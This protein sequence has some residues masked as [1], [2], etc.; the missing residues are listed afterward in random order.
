VGSHVIVC[1]RSD[2]PM[3]QDVPA[4][5]ATTTKVTTTRTTTTYSPACSGRMPPFDLPEKSVTELDDWHNPSEEPSEMAT[6]SPPVVVSVADDRTAKLSSKTTGEQVTVQ[7][8]SDFEGWDVLEITP[9][10][11]VV[12]LEQA[13]QRWASIAFVVQGRD[14]PLATVRKPVGQIDALEQP[15]YHLEEVDSDWYCK[16]NHDV[17]D[18][19]GKVAGSISDGEP[20][21][22][23]ASSVFAPNNDNGIFGNP[24]E[25]AKWVLRSDGAVKTQDFPRAGKSGG[26]VHTSFRDFLPTS[27]PQHGGHAVWESSKGGMVGKHLRVVEQGFWDSPSACGGSIMAVSPAAT[28]QD[29]ESTAL[30]RV[31]TRASTNKSTFYRRLRVNQTSSELLGIDELDNGDDFFDAVLAQYHRWG[32]FVGFGSAPLLPDSDRRYRD[33]PNA[34]LTAYLNNFRGMTP[35]YGMG[36]FAN[37][38][39]EFLPLDTLSLHEGLLEWGHHDVSRKYLSHFF[40]T[41][42]NHT[43]GKIIYDIFNCDGDAD[44]GRLVSTYVKAA[45]YSGDRKWAASLLPVIENMAN[46]I[47]QARAATMEEFPAESLLHGLARGSP[48]HDLCGGKSFFFNVNVWMIRGLL[49]LDGFLKESGLSNDPSIEVRLLPEASDW[50]VRLTAAANY[51]AVRKVD[52]SVFFLHPCVGSDCAKTPVLKQGGLEKNCVDAGICF[53]SMT[54]DRK[55]QIA[56]YA[57]FRFYSET[58]FATVLDEEYENGIITFRDTHRGTLTGMTRFRDVL[59]DMPILGYG[60]GLLSHDKVEQF[61]T[62]LAG[63]SANY[64]SRGT[65]WGTEQRQQQQNGGIL[66]D[67]WTNNCGDGGEDCSLCMVSSMPPAMWVRWML[68][69]ESRDARQVHLAR[70]APKR[71][72]TQSQAFGISAAPTRFG[73][74]SYSL[75]AVD[76]SI[77]GIVTLSAHPGTED[78]EN[79]LYS[80]RLISP[81]WKDGLQLDTVDVSGAMVIAIHQNNNT[82]VFSPDA[83]AGSFNFTATFAKGG[84]M[85]V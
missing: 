8:G 48:E 1:V 29:P 71:W 74:V 61:H 62:L 21:F 46:H 85:L 44:Y 57:N 25:L 7:V 17:E 18:W 66:D 53:P 23:A 12:V 9:S 54:A 63:H 24:E 69:Q 3:T 82:V 81:E 67:R 45:R 35:E 41:F 76:S 6:L 51:T 11:K 13:F 2:V 43:D 42:I 22:N 78:A 49:D 55:N 33:M 10:N 56:N 30:I 50:R 65:H 47:L 64:I 52:G 73:V 58:L 28:A 84:M 27:C 20:T 68:V 77:Q 5:C 4:G 70:G 40:N 32:D 36:K 31:V 72:F 75:R 37:K 80:V 34:L 16:Q 15:T 59:D 79:V 19:V 14:T 26:F 60:W 38:Y 39:N 83:A